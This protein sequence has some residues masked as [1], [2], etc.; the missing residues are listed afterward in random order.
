MVTVEGLR[1]LDEGQRFKTLQESGLP[2]LDERPRMLWHCNYY[3]GALSGVC[4]HDGRQFWFEMVD[5]IP[6]RAD[7]GEPRLGRVFAV[8]EMTPEQ[9]RAERIHHMLWRACVGTHSDYDEN[10]K[11]DLRKPYPPT[12]LPMRLLNHI[13]PRKSYWVWVWLR[14][15]IPLERPDFDDAPIVCWWK[16]SIWSFD[17]MLFDAMDEAGVSIGEEVGDGD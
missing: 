9:W 4:R 14:G 7:D 10:N 15:K 3:D 11:R 13:A 1:E 8:C 16:H 12:F 17:G 2:E 5:E 6:F